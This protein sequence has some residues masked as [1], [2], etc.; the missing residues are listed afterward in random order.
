MT[1]Q[2]RSTT[3]MPPTVACE[4]VF[5]LPE[6][7]EKILD[8][9]S[10]TPLKLFALRRVNSTFNDTINMRKYH[11]AMF[12]SP[13][14]KLRILDFTRILLAKNLRSATYPFRII[15]FSPARASSKLMLRLEMEKAFCQKMLPLSVVEWF[16][17]D[18]SYTKKASWQDVLICPGQLQ[19]EIDLGGRITWQYASGRDVPLGRIIRDAVVEVQAHSHRNPM[20]YGLL[21]RD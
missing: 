1:M 16:L 14:P 20:R 8:H 6:L 9:V 2:A 11:C 12:L 18:M 10:T 3:N 17:E 4:Q 7:V 13:S 21:Q 5:A 19:V 15:T